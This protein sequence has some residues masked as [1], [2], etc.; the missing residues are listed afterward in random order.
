MTHPSE[1]ILFENDGGYD[2]N[3]ATNAAVRNAFLERNL[4]EDHT[5]VFW[6]DIDIVDYPADIIER[7]LEGDGISA[8]LVLM[9]RTSHFYDIGS[10]VQDGKW[11]SPRWPYFDITRPIEGVGCIYIIP[12]LV[13]RNTK[14]RPIKGYTEHRSVMMDALDLRVPIQCRLDTIAW[15]AYLKDFEMRTQ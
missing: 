2:K 3:Y 12:A 4:R 1:I 9:E 13:L 14:Y 11:A 8:P 6:V 15:H 10:F 7:L 5:H